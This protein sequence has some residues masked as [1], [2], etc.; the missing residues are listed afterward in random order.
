MAPIVTPRSLGYLLF[1]TAVGH[2]GLAWG[3][4]AL[5][6]VLLPEDGGA[7]AT[8]RRMRRLHPSSTE[9]LEEAVPPLARMAVER[10]RGLLRGEKDDLRDLPLDMSALPAF[11]RRVYELIRQTGPGQTTTYGEIAASL[12]EPAAARAVGQAM[13][14]NPF[15]PVVPCHRVLA[16]AG[17][18]GSYGS[19]GFSAGGGLTTKLR[20]LQI[21]GARLS[22][23]RGLFD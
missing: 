19:G 8:R 18:S 14:R 3:E 15:A 5:T 2:C 17:P 4:D 16:A 13:A 20:M 11:N 22:R 6:G 23:E 21:E 12:G 9:T 1:D 7:E 10:I